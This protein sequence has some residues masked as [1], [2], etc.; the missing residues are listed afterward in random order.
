MKNNKSSPS[1]K[2][3]LKEWLEKMQQESWQLELIISGIALFGIYESYPLVYEFGLYLEE[4]AYGQ[5]RIILYSISFSLHI[6]WKLFFINLLVHFI[7]R[8][9]WI[10]VIGLRYVSGELEIDNLN[11]S[12]NFTGYL[13]RKTG[14]F[15]DFIERLEKICSIVFAYTF[16]LFC[17]FF[18]FVM[19]VSMLFALSYLV[20][21]LTATSS[22]KAKQFFDFVLV[23]LY[24]FLGILTFIDFITLGSL[25]K[26]RSKKF[27]N[28]FLIPFRFFSTITLSFLYRP[29]LYNFLDHPY[30]RNLFLLSIPYMLMIIFGT[31]SLKSNQFPHFQDQENLIESGLM[32]NDLHYEDRM[33]EKYFHLNEDDRKVMLNDIPDF[34][35]SQ[36][37]MTKEYQSIFIKMHQSDQDLYEKKYSIQPFFRSGLRL[38]FGKPNVF[39]DDNIKIFE[40]QFAKLAWKLVDEKKA[41]YRKMKHLEKTNTEY[42]S[43]FFDDQL[44]SLESEF[45]SIVEDHNNKLDSI[46]IK[47]EIQLDNA[48]K[49]RLKLHIDSLDYTDSILCKYYLHPT[50]QQKGH[51]C[52]FSI[53][54]LKEGHHQLKISR[55]YY[56]LGEKDSIRSVNK[57]L[58]FIKT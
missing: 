11:Y 2:A 25:K 12:D 21:I 15:D 47:K 55:N 14:T 16:L 8:G 26:I 49:D 44:D 35:L 5:A 34:I 43:I 40:A 53:G 7:L 9:L 6:G 17:L 29:L 33:H 32:I 45:E 24:L 38:D 58:P 52:F 20:D 13:K 57:I 19:Y 23:A 27:S 28:L 50:Y 54:N 51:L 18:S 30:T 39:E 36:F 56:R 48:F 41:I 22:P 1:N 4:S 31:H 37:E 10:G 3:F 42:D 46:D